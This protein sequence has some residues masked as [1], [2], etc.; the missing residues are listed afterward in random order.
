MLRKRPIAVAITA[1]AVMLV[2]AGCMVLP[3]KFVSDLSLRRDGTFT[4]HYKG[5]IVLAALAQGSKSGVTDTSAT[6]SEFGA[7][8][9]KF[10]A[11]PCTDPAT[12]E[13]H[14]CTAAELAAQRTQWNDALRERKASKAGEDAQKTKM[15]Q[16]MMGGIDP[17]D[18]KAAQAFADRL[19]R[20][21]GWTSVVSKGHG[22]FEVEYS[23]AGRLDHDFTFPTIERMPM[24]IPFVAIIRRSD[25]TVRVDA[26]A[27]SP[28]AA[29]PMIPGLS[30]MGGA[31]GAKSSGKAEGAPVADGLFTL[32]TDGQILANNT[33][34]GPKA[35]PATGGSR[36]DWKV[37]ARTAAAPTALIK[38]G[39]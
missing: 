25:G 35:E 21:Q 8:G 11:N 15:M 36:L 5:E 4:F 38:L 22:K 9:E 17:E 19:A 30:A 37:D 33:D 3:G 24:V 39:K 14:P 27:F 34:E 23:A 12:D 28:G 31:M 7:L 16:A 26:P 29:N 18:P 2:L 20:Q 32:R 1:A 13:A 10:E 6:S